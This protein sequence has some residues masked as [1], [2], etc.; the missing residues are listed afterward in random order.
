LF[1]LFQH[2]SMVR[3]ATPC[4]RLVWGVSNLC[5]EAVWGVADYIY[6]KGRGQDGNNIG[7]VAG[8][9]IRSVILGLVGASVDSDPKVGCAVGALA[10]TATYRRDLTGFA[11][12]CWR[13][14][15]QSNSTRFGQ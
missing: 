9:A 6:P 15:F 12:S 14:S 8:V 13:R 11:R 4:Y 2:C 7:S 10:L 3:H 1:Y 5:A